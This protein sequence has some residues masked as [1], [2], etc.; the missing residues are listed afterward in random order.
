MLEELRTD[1]SIADVRA[2]L[3]ERLREYGDV[4]QERRAPYERADDAWRIVQN[5]LA[6]E[7]AVL[8]AGL[9]SDAQLREKDRLALQDGSQAID[10]IYRGAQF[11]IVRP[12]D[13]LNLALIDPVAGRLPIVQLGSKLFIAGEPI[14]AAL[15]QAVGRLVQH[16]TT[17]VGPTASKPRYMTLELLASNGA[18]VEAALN[19]AFESGFRF[20][21]SYEGSGRHRRVFV[22]ER[23]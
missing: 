13:R 21:E 11:S 6:E 10:V 9:P 14:A 22:F 8:N 15:L 7:L 12:R 4:E 20:V 1:L 19:L 3:R 16:A 5:V 2:E 23:V 17:G 18:R